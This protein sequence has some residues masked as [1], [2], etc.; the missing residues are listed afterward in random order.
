MKT[1]LCYGDSNTWGF[2]PGKNR[3]P[4]KA[5]NRYPFDIR[6][7]GLLETKLGKDWRVLEE[8]L[9]G[10]TTMFDCFLEEHRNG[11]KDI[12]VCLLS[13]MPVDVVLLMLGT[14]DC[15]QV[16]GK[17][18][19]IISQGINRLIHQIKGGL[20][21]YGPEGCVPQIL[22]VSPARITEGVLTSWLAGEFDEESIK[23]CSLLGEYYRKTAA[24]NDV[25]YLDA[26]ALISAD[27]ADGIHM[28]VEG[29]A[30]MADLIYDKLMEMT[31][32]CRQ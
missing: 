1:I 22:V 31:N 3:P 12:D 13:S 30:K 4:V 25:F 23:R 5:A 8:G 26:G 9:N 32:S 11:L 16:F 7:P 14:N 19:Y 17:S 28:N 27:D 6:W 21:G 2:I 29:H 20:Y 15:K 18:P 24:D 10:R